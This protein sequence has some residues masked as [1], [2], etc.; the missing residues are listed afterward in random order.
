MYLS[1]GHM[2]YTAVMAGLQI[3]LA[4]PITGIMLLI[5]AVDIYYFMDYMAGFVPFILEFGFIAWLGIMNIRRFIHASR[6]NR[7]FTE[8]GFGSMT[9]AQAADKLNISEEACQ[10]RFDQLSSIGLLK[11][12]HYECENT[13]RFVLHKKQ[14][15]DFRGIFIVILQMTAFFGIGLSGFMLFIFIFSLLSNLFDGGLASMDE[16]HVLLMITILFAAMLAGCL[17]IR[18]VIGCAYRFSNYF[19]GNTGRIVPAAQIARAFG[20]IEN[21]VTA[22]FEK[23]TRWGLLTGWSLQK[24]PTPQ[25]IPNEMVKAP[26]QKPQF[27][28]KSAEIQSAKKYNAV[29]CPNCGASLMLETSKVEQC[30]YCDSWLEI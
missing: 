13:A 20:R 26:M 17:K 5:A 4:L 6:F 28:P 19:S 8:S 23:L 14:T 10:K 16:P 30:P 15:D 24:T 3:I 27:T 9:A 12:C 21:A 7:I 18:N 1:K 22:E 29:N 2:V 25:F 11:H